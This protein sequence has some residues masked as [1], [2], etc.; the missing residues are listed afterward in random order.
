MRHLAGK[1]G[2]SSLDLA[3]DILEKAKVAVTPGIDFGQGAEGYIR[4]S[5]ATSMENI[6]EGMDRLE[7][8]LKEYA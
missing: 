6:K 4:F 8:Y 3:Y 1:F 7:A 2:G 5:Y